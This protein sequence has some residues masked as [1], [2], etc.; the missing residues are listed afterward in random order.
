MTKCSVPVSLKNLS[1]SFIFTVS[2]WIGLTLNFLSIPPWDMLSFYFVS[3]VKR[4]HTFIFIKKISRLEAIQQDIFVFFDPIHFS[5]DPIRHW[6]FFFGPFQVRFY[7]IVECQMFF[8]CR[9]DMLHHL[10]LPEIIL[11]DF[12][13]LRLFTLNTSFE[14][15]MYILKKIYLYKRNFMQC[16][17]Y[18]FMLLSLLYAH[19][20]SFCDSFLSHCF[21]KS[22][23]NSMTHKKD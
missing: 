21:K 16:R 20:K 1:L 3:Y 18:F 10:S 6:Y 19:E 15:L 14:I 13:I 4:L 22:C 9:Q 11:R 23:R 12:M 8:M 5:F 17:W 2:G 7:I